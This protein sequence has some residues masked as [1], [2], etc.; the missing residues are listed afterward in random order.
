MQIRHNL[1]CNFRLV[2]RVQVGDFVDAQDTAGKWFEAYV[3]EV[4]QDTVKVHY[5]GWSSKWDTELPKDYSTS[6]N[7][8]FAKLSPP[9]PLWSHSEN[10]REHL[11]EGDIVEVREAGSSIRK[12][13]SIKVQNFSMTSFLNLQCLLP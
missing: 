2:N 1:M 12:P 8:K 13:V 7:S 6:P 9:Q 5:F 4:K 11:Q 10:W 3:S